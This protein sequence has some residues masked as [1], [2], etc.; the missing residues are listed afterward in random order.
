[1]ETVQGGQCDFSDP[2]DDVARER[3]KKKDLTAV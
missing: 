1:M 3:D 2:R